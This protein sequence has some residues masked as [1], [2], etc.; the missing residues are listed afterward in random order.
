M[1]TSSEDKKPGS[2]KPTNKKSTDKP[3]DGRNPNRAGGP[4][5]IESDR[6]GG[7]GS[8]RGR[9]RRGPRRSPGDTDGDFVNPYDLAF[10]A[11]DG[12]GH[13]GHRG[14]RGGRGRGA[15]R[16]RRGEVRNGVITM[17]AE[18]PKHGYQLIQEMSD[19]SGGAWAPSPGSI[20]P[21]LQRLSEAGVV[22]AEDVEDG[23]RI[24]RL[25]AVGQVA[26]ERLAQRGDAP[27]V[28]VGASESDE[29]K[30]LR[31]LTGQ[32]GAAV[33]QVAQ[34]ATPD[35]LVRAAAIVAESRRKLYALLAEDPSG[36]SSGEPTVS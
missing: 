13:P 32:L 34:V 25:T 31:V 35:Q 16:A 11:P 12:R 5:S 14:H 28:T 8:P 2:K 3:T 29:A 1:S 27:W 17:L 23:R 7:P 20:Y 33:T 21:I 30:E 24:F 19:R 36:D 10:D 9:G 26:A 22:E 15:P 18:G 6:R 4:D